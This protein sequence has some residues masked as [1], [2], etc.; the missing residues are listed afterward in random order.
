MTDVLNTAFYLP[1]GLRGISEPAATASLA[2][3][4]MC[5]DCVWI[6][7]SQMRAAGTVFA[8]MGRNAFRLALETGAIRFVRDRCIYAWPK[9][10]GYNG[11]VPILVISAMRGENASRGAALWPTGVLASVALGEFDLSP[12]ETNWFS[13]AIAKTASDAGFTQANQTD[14]LSGKSLTEVT[15]GDLSRWKGLIE[16]SSGLNLTGEDIDRLSLSVST[17][18]KSPLHGANQLGIFEGTTASGQELLKQR[19][20]L[21]P[22]Q[23]DLLNLVISDRLL[24]V[25]QQV[26]PQG[27][28]HTDSLL[29]AVLRSL[30]EGPRAAAGVEMD[31]LLQDEEI[32]LPSPDE[33]GNFP[34]EEL[35]LERQT[36][37]AQA[38]RE[39]VSRRDSRP[40]ARLIQE[41]LKQ[42]RGPVGSR[43]LVRAARFLIGRGAALMGPAV[44]IAAQGIDKLVVENALGMLDATYFVDTQLR[45]MADRSQA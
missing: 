25:R 29:E 13:G 30:L 6:V 22:K 42:L 12:A 24:H 15:L 44:G 19:E 20:A 35:I 3:D 28:L 40:D 2:Q 23:L 34:F 45:S 4:L 21:A 8:A 31:Q 39:L 18:S 11:L 32:F 16:R 9:R 5:Y 38:F 43:F 14:S 1:Y 41:Y 7:S 36:D 26:A 17:P 27:T 33:P 37:A 10:K